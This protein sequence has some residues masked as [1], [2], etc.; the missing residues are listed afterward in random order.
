MLPTRDSR[1][2]TIV[3]LV[4]VGIALGGS[5]LFDWQWGWNPSQPVPLAIGVVAAV[6]ALGVT[7]AWLRD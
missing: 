1:L 5:V 4:V 7:I 3:G 2:G 6:V